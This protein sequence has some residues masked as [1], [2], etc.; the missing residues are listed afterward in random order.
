MHH[1]LYISEILGTLFQYTDR[2]TDVA[3]TRVCKA[4]TSS[5]LDV[6]W[7]RVDRLEALFYLLGPMGRVNSD[8]KTAV[9]TLLNYHIA[10]DRW[11]RFA[12]FAER[13]RHIEFRKRRTMVHHDSFST[14]AISRPILNLFPNLMRITWAHD[15]PARSLPLSSL[16][17]HPGVRRLSVKT[18]ADGFATE[19]DLYALDNF[20]TDVLFRAPHI[21]HL[22]MCSGISYRKVGPGLEAFLCGLKSLKTLVVSESYLTSDVVIALAQC[23]D[24]EVV[25]MHPPDSVHSHLEP[26]D[27]PN[28]ME[29]FMP[30]VHQGA[31]PRI[32]EMALKANLWGCTHFLQ[33]PFPASQLQHLHIIT[34][35][36]E[37][38]ADI[39]DFFAVLAEEC[40]RLVYFELF[41]LHEDAGDD[42]FGPITFDVIAPLRHLHDIEHLKLNIPSQ[43]QMLDSNLLYVVAGWPRIR[44]L[45][46]ATRF[47]WDSPIA[48]IGLDI[49]SPIARLC[50]ELRSLYMF[51][52]PY[53]IPVPGDDPPEAFY[54]FQHL[55]RL[56]TAVIGTRRA[57]ADIAGYLA[58]VIPP[59]CSIAMLPT[60][61]I[62]GP[63]V[64]SL[65]VDTLAAV[66]GWIAL[67]FEALE[68]MPMLRRVH[69]QYQARLRSLEEQVRQL[70]LQAPSDT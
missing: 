19:N 69:A 55:E 1:A 4:W 59:S 64:T 32:K 24:L 33:S 11:A 27:P 8:T 26:Q 57:P 56:E 10:P 65:E 62:V 43:L 67:F 61:H 35:H 42:S 48:P 28:E 34:P 5:A 30:F 47:V 29:E 45:R 58:Q 6:V 13:I 63:A 2:R 36:F 12:T 23:P 66:H 21:E 52:N 16:F 22:D 3:C 15:P 25:R 50:P 44:T 54:P 46:L 60:Y 38:P 41:V 17:L 51:F 40:P 37:L 53:S 68:M 20:F 9:L 7:E 18:N 49:L 70:T 39:G 14:L 31:F